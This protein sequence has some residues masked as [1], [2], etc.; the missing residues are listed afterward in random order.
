MQLICVSLISI[1][2]RKFLEYYSVN[3][4]HEKSKKA[5][6]AREA[7]EVYEKTAPYCM[8]CMEANLAV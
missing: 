1:D 6:L 4:L 2:S 7:I 5:S 8:L 3:L